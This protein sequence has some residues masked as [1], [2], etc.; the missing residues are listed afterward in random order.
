LSPF[1]GITYKLLSAL[2]FT[3]MSAAIKSISARYPTGE[4]VF[5]RSAFA[6]IPLL[7]WL[8]WR[9]ELPAALKTTNLGGHLKRGIMGSTGMFCGFAALQFLP[10]SEAVAIGYAAPLVVVVLA[11]LILKERVR[12]YRWSA[13]AIGFLGVLIMLSPHLG[14]GAVALGPQA[15]LGAAFGL[16]GAFGSAFASVE[17]RQLTQTERTGAIV[18]YFMLLTSLLGLSTILLGW[19]LPDLRDGLTMVVIGILGGF[20]QILIVQAYRY[21]DASLVAPFE[22][23]TMLWAVAIGWFWFGEWP[24]TTIIIGAFIV[25]SSGI[26][27]ILREHQLGLARRAQREAGPSRIT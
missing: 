5:A 20:G 1:L 10:L 25:I 27:V 8:A 2:A 15:A 23:S 4:I 14:V 24:A 3:L 9:A 7:I 13:V 21:G 17:V 6:M 19:N 11:A 18:F 12:I 16:A 26:Y 22:Y